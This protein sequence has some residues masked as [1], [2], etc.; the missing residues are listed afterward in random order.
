MIVNY[1][2][3]P[4]VF[5]VFV[6]FFFFG[7]N[8]SQALQYQVGNEATLTVRLEQSCKEASLEGLEASNDKRVGIN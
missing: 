3:Y 5:P 2:D 6:V 8:C 1:V 4:P 7:R